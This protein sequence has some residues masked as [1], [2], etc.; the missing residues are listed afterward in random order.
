MHI[1]PALDRGN[2]DS[3]SEWRVDFQVPEDSVTHLVDGRGRIWMDGDELASVPSMSGDWLLGQTPDGVV[4]CVRLVEGHENM[5]PLTFIATSL[6]DTDALL[7]SIGVALGRWH[8]ADRY[9]CGCGAEVE[10]IEAGWATKCMSCERIE[11]PRTD[12]A[13]IVLVLDEQERALL[14]HNTMWPDDLMMSLPAGFVEA[15]ESPRRAVERELME[16]VGV[17]VDDVSYLAA[18][19]WPGPRSL[20][21]GCKAVATSTKVVPDGVEIDRARFFSRG[22]YMAAIESGEVRA[23]GPASIAHAILKAWLGQEIPTCRN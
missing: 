17:S 11:Y 6:S 21:I 8:F 1:Q 12:P 20:M 15:G 18:Q 16:E 3:R 14:A 19:P 13:V 10:I 7:G 9:C 2:V 23:P 5:V 22:E 4:H